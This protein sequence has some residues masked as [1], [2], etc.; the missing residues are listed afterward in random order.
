MKS[1]NALQKRLGYYFGN[2]KLLEMAL[3]HSSWA[4][5]RQR[6]GMHNERL[7]FLGDAVLELCSSIKLYHLFPEAREGEL[8]YLRATLVSEKALAARAMEIGLNKY[9]LLGSGEEKQGG[10]ERDAI[11]CD[12]FEAVL[13][14]IYE[15]GGLNAAMKV[16]EK[17][18]AGHWPTEWRL[19]P[20]RDFKS[21]LQE[22]IQHLYKGLPVYS[23]ESSSGPEH[24]KIFEIRLELPDGRIYR[25]K[26]SSCK[27]AEQDCAAIALEDLGESQACQGGSPQSA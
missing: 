21:R 19:K 6:P 17:V 27:K 1:L 23:L 20:G 4:N 24:A 25:A 8:T 18:F 2:K 5:E 15:D 11:L 22:V 7:E 10:R 12:A 3:T 16:I 14:A 9:L 26:N 13:G